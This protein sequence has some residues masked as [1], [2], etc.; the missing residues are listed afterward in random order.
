MSLGATRVM[1][2]VSIVEG[3]W[4]RIAIAWTLVACFRQARCQGAQVRAWRSSRSWNRPARHLRGRGG[5][6]LRRAGFLHH[7]RTLVIAGQRAMVQASAGIVADS[8]PSA[9]FRRP[10][11]RP[12]PS[13]APS[14]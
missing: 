5:A 10:G 12:A 7:H 9:D 8:N 6:G 3:S 11:T 13:L 2:L 1:H 4:P 14:S